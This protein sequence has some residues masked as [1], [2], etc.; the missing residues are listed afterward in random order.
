M[1]ASPEDD[2]AAR[3]YVR[4]TRFERSRSVVQ[5][6]EK[7]RRTDGYAESKIWEGLLS[8]REREGI[9]SRECTVLPDVRLKVI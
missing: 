4:Q 9:P 3:A 7:C 2:R 6:R 5:N 8:K 1:G